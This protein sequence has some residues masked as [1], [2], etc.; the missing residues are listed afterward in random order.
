MK[1]I[2]A[3]DIH[4]SLYYAEK[5]I[6]KFKKENADKLIL[7]GDLYYHGPR[8]PLPK[9]YAPMKVAALFNSYKDKICVVR[10]N[11]D[12]NIDLTISE[13]PFHARK[14][15]S[16]NGRKILFTHGDKYNKDN[17]P[18]LPKGSVIIYG[19]YHVN[20]ITEKN[21]ITC[22]NL[23]SASM[24]KNGCEPSYA[25]IE[26]GKIVVRSLETDRVILDFVL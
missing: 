13:F 15:L 16:I 7:L 23:A 17:L 19:H 22:I 2:I 24:P 25:V 9:D 20:E 5:I 3:T 26:G 6:E 21:G 18:P 4:G 12:A 14:T 10:G 8:N 11:C 1:I